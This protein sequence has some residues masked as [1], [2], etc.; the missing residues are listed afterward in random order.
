MQRRLQ[1]VQ[2]RVDVTA[3]VVVNTPVGP[4]TPLALPNTQDIVSM[5]RLVNDAGSSF[6]REA[7]RQPRLLD[8][9]GNE[10]PLRVVDNVPTLDS[11]AESSGDPVGYLAKHL[12]DKRF[13]EVLA[14]EM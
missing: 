14:G 11:D 8:P 7:G 5:G 9:H 12:A 6:H 3:G 10:I 1:T 13:E 4:L 2:G